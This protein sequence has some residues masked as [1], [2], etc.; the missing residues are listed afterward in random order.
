VAAIRDS[1]IAEIERKPFKY[2]QS[3]MND[4]LGAAIV[5]EVVQIISEGGLI[6]EAERK[7]RILLDQLQS[8]TDPE[9][10][11]EVRG[12]GLMVAVDLINEQ[13]TET[14]HDKLIS[15][16]YIVGNRRTAIRIDPPLIIEEHEI[17]GFIDTFAKV[18]KETHITPA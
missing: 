8:L 11:P 14:L 9:T 18:L 5:R 1:I 3:H 15:R 6:A 17:K 4:P 12:R 2:G 13:A 16:G 7:G 10:M